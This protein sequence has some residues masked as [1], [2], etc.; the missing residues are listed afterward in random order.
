[1]WGIYGVQAGNPK[2]RMIGY[3]HNKNEGL[4]DEKGNSL[5]VPLQIPTKS[6]SLIVRLYGS[7]NGFETDLKRTWNGL[8]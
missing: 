2:M 3:N 6:H 7:G 5:T 1:M 8:E 4:E